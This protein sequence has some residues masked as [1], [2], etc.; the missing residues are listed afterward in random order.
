MISLEMKCPQLSKPEVIAARNQ[1]S[2][3]DRT[4]KK[5]GRK[6]A[7]SGGRFSSG[8]TN[9]QFV[10]RTH[11]VPEVLSH[12]L[13][14]RQGLHWGS[15]SGAHLVF[16]IPLT[17]GAVELISRCWYTIWAGYG[18]DPVTAVTIW[19]GYKANWIWWLWW[20]RNN[21]KIDYIS[22]QAILLTM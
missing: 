16:L 8:Q 12:W 3:G 18:L 9:Q 5:P 22:V 1:N 2:I 7:Q 21:K 6:Q 13:S 11:L 4:E 14:R 20:P 10:L 15:V 19:S 17:F